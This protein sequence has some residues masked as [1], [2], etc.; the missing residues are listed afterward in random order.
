MNLRL[1]SF[2]LAAASLLACGGDDA[3]KQAVAPQPTYAP[4]PT[5]TQ[6]A[7]AQPAPTAAQPAPT[8]PAPAAGSATG[9]AQ[10]MQ[11][12][13]AAAATTPLQ[14]YAN[15]EAPGMAKDGP[16]TAGTFQEGQYLEQQFT[17]QPGKCYT[18]VAGAVG[19]TAIEVEMQYVT[20][21]PGLA[22][23]IGKSTQKGTQV[24]MGGKANCMRP[25]SPIAAPAKYI[26]RVTKG[27][28]LAAAQL[29]SK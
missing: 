13:L 27:A 10:P 20:P 15:T 4:A 12:A 18:L 8:Q 21:L 29:Y 1:L 11:E 6:P 28:G 3:N 14:M 2:S 19:P 17:F 9:T 16:A 7:P 22:P 26:L 25:L 24:S 5:Y 23:S